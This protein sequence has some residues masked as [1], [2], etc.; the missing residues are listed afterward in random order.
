LLLIIVIE[1]GYFDI[2]R[3]LCPLQCRRTRK[4]FLLY[5]FYDSNGTKTFI[6]ALLSVVDYAIP[7][8]L[9]SLILF[10][11]LLQAQFSCES[12]IQGCLIFTFSFIVFLWSVTSCYSMPFPVTMTMDSGF[13]FHQHG[14]MV[15]M[16]IILPAMLASVM[17]KSS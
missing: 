17:R 1:C 5:L 3:C 10:D 8:G 12:F 4:R 2:E 11:D 14:F 6:T 9:L 16:L 13:E 15:W 7:F